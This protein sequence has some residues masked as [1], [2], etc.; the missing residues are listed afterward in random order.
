MAEQS[1]PKQEEADVSAHAPHN[2]RQSKNSG[3]SI[4]AEKFELPKGEGGNAGAR[5]FSAVY[6]ASYSESESSAGKSVGSINGQNNISHQKNILKNGS[7]FPVSDKRKPLSQESRFAAQRNGIFPGKISAVSP[8][9]SSSEPSKEKQDKLARRGHNESLLNSD[10]SAHDKA[11]ALNNPKQYSA[12]QKG[13]VH[14]T[15]A[16]SPPSAQR[17]I[18][19]ADMFTQGGLPSLHIPFEPAYLSDLFFRFPPRNFTAYRAAN[20]LPLFSCLFNLLTTLEPEQ[21]RRLKTHS[22]YPR[23]AKFLSYR[24]LFVGTTVSEFTPLPQEFSASAARNTVSGL[25]RQAKKYP[26]LIVK[27]LPREASS[28]ISPE[29]VSEAQRF[30]RALAAKGFMSVEGQAL[31][32]VPVDYADVDEY[33]AR[34]SKTRRKDFRR[35]MK[36]GERLKID[37][38]Y[39]GDSAFYDRAQLAEYYRLYEQVYRQSEVHFDFLSPDFFK[40]LLQEAGEGLRFITYRDE[41]GRLIGYNICFIVGDRLVDKY[42][43]LDYPAATDYSLYFVSWFFNLSYA[44]RQGLS[45]YIAGWTDPQVKAYLGAKFVM[46]RHRVYVRNPLLRTILRPLRPLFESDA[47]AAAGGKSGRKKKGKPVQDA[48]NNGDNGEA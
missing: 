5:V 37:I 9:E 21:L 4:N 33:I 3:A 26:F 47:A 16:E 43:G 6:G 39:K 45:Y 22:F 32:Y 28:L 18:T 44:R 24:T 46:T 12:A 14:N 25:L 11:E 31:A 8:Q 1:N 35:K 2:F 29:L 27:D 10:G 42:I 48:N 7:D 23:L 30:D 36:A 13:V 34:F 40:A 17:G 41:A 20:G 38:L 19:G 15:S